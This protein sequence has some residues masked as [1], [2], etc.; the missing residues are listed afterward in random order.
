MTA[1]WL[2]GDTRDVTAA[3]P[4]GTIDLVVTSP[5]FLALRSYLPADHPD[6][7][8]EIGSEATPAAFT[9]TLLE[10]S[11][12]WRRILAPH[13]SLCVELGDTYS[14]SGGEATRP[15]RVTPDLRRAPGD[16]NYHADQQGD[17]R[18]SGGPGWP[19]AKCL[20]LIPELYR[21]ALAYGTHPLTGNP[22]PAGRWKVRN[23][24]RWV[25]PNPPV[26]AL[27]DKF[28]PAT[29]DMVVACTSAKRWFDLDAVRTAS[30][31]DRPNLKGQGSRG[32]GHDVPGQKRNQS[33]HTTNPAGAPPLDWWQ[34]SPG[35]YQGAHYAV[36]P[37]E[38]VVRPI[39]AMC[40]R[41]VCRTCGTPSTR[42]THVDGLRGV[43]FLGSDNDRDVGLHGKRPTMPDI[44]RTTLGWSTC[45][46]PGTEPDRLDGYHTDTGWRPGRVLDPF[47]GSGTTGVVATGHSR[48]FIGID[49]DERNH[50]LALDRIGAM[51][52]Q[53]T[54]PDQLADLLTATPTPQPT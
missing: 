37:A 13:G 19:D 3:I 40:P 4:D 32:P 41:R 15:A 53:H 25:R 50:D 20:A 48:D 33:D 54:T 38:L 47:A 39:E 30:D 45:G 35:G 14:G 9:S 34:I 12:E 7:A 16:D 17:V 2:T 52:L 28:R 51:F 6:K 8:R 1:Y 24:V 11:A 18:I 49:L 22:S 42:I 23:V 43:D 46:C 44:T 26:G 31:Y 36:F 27:G 5:P 10:L 29:S 21:I